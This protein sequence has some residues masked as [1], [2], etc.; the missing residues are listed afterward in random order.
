MWGSLC[1]VNSTIYSACHKACIA[2]NMAMPI[3]YCTSCSSYDTERDVLAK[4][5]QMDKPSTVR[6]DYSLTR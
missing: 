4:T 2:E 1:N 6:Q 5:K 3:L